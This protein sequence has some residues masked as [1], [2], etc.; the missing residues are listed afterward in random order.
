MSTKKT[1]EEQLSALYHKPLFLSGRTIDLQWFQFGQINQ[2]KT[3]SGRWKEVGEYALHIQCC[4][5]IVGLE[6]VIVG[7]EDRYYPSSSAK[8]IPDDFDWDKPGNN[9]CDANMSSFINQYCPLNVKSIVV[10]DIGGFSLLFERSFRL[11]VFPVSSLENE[12][13]RLFKPGEKTSPHFVLIGNVLTR[14]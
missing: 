10:D 9:R 8:E 6:G 13:W 14:E 1:V 11:E 7:S 2:I 5:R 3:P 4:W 12:H